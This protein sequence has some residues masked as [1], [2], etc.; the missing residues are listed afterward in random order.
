M[1]AA[2]R[3]RV[4][5]WG[6]RLIPLAV[7]L[8]SGSSPPVLMAQSPQAVTVIGLD[9][10]FQAPDTLPAGP[11]TLS[12]LNRG[13]VRHELI[14]LLLNEGRTLGELLQATTLEARTSLSRPLGLI[15]AQPGQPADAQLIVN[16]VPGRSYVFLCVLR[17]APD[18]PPHSAMGMAKALV[19]K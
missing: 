16:L 7:V 5:V 19:V 14:L 18:K 8:L 4:L 2:A 3:G 15:F 12:L 10:A 13:T 1:I 17:D 11:V 6:G 9:Y